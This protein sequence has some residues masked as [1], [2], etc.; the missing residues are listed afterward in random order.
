[1]R[2]KKKGAGQQPT[3]SIMT[4]YL[5]RLY[6]KQTFLAI[7]HPALNNRLIVNG[8]YR[9]VLKNDIP[10]FSQRLKHR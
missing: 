8:A 3:P 5:E 9:I 7:D 2:P 1:M 4:V 6:S 10:I